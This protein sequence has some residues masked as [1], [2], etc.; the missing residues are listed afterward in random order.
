MTSNQS[1]GALFDQVVALA[2][3]QELSE[4]PKLE[5]IVNFVHNFTKKQSR[6]VLPSYTE[7]QKQEV[8]D[9]VGT[10]AEK[11]IVAFE[12]VASLPSIR[13]QQFARLSSDKELIYI[14]LAN[15]TK[16]SNSTINLYYMPNNDDITGSAVLTVSKHKKS[17]KYSYDVK[18]GLSPDVY[19][20]LV[21]LKNECF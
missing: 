15:D 8:V 17:G 10:E 20:R 4:N 5:A 6:L 12:D 21:A 18:N 1:A 16:D 14:R 19:N 3:E 2:A 11:Q 7:E 13:H 9:W